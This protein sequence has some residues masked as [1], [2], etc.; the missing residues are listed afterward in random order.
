MAAA[1]EEHRRGPAG[2]LQLAAGGRIRVHALRER[3]RVTLDVSIADGWHINAHET[4]D[5]DLQ[6][7][8]VEGGHDTRL[9]EVRYPAGERMSP[10]FRQTPLNL[11][12]GNVRIDATLADDVERPTIFLRLQACDDQRCLAAETLRFPLPR[13]GADSG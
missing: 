11:Y 10:A 13:L 12:R 7:T 5:A 3:S 9:A 4:G 8:S 2:R 1:A 6:G